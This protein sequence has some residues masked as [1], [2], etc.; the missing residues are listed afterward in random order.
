MPHADEFRDEHVL[1]VFGICVGRGDGID[2]LAVDLPTAWARSHTR[3]DVSLTQAGDEF[4]WHAHLVGDDDEH[5]LGFP[6]HDHV[7]KMLLA[8]R[9]GGLP[10]DL[11]G[12]WDDLEQGWWASAIPAGSRVYLAETDFDE[13]VDKAREPSNISRTGPGKVS[14][15]GV[16]VRWNSVPRVAYDQAW[17]R[18]IG[19][20]RR[21]G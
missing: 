8:R 4:G 5:L 18:A 1:R 9:G 10:I 16:E 21:T 6:W 13:L 15:D 19:R 17:E 2:V 3:V 7:E 14:V 12:A 20:F 11:A